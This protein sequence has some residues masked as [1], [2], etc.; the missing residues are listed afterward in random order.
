ME[1]RERR[2]RFWVALQP[3][4]VRL[5][6]VA[7]L[8][9]L[10]AILVGLAR[11]PRRQHLLLLRQPGCARSCCRRRTRRSSRRRR[12]L[13]DAQAAREP[14][15]HREARDR[16]ATSP[17][18]SA[19]SRSTTSSSPT[20]AP[21]PMRR[22]R[23]SSGCS[24]AR[25]IEAKLDKENAV[26]RRAPL[27]AR[28][29]SLALR[30]KEQE[31]VVNRLEQSPYLRAVNGKVVLAFVPYQNLRNIKIGTKLYGCSWG[32]VVCSRV[33]K[34]K[35]D[36]RRRGAGH[37][38]ARRE[39]AARRDGRDRAVDAVGRR[40]TPCCSPAASRSGCS[41]PSS[42]AELIGID[43]VDRDRLVLECAA[44]SAGA[45]SQAVSWR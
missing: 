20:S 40:R 45:Q 14:A 34:V 13:A 38:P 8:V 3:S 4:I 28:L 16:G 7:G 23:P 6:K 32:L 9:A 44:L 26:G 18:S 27:E 33:G 15:R 11:L 10:T 21:P 24:A 36:A 1:A 35:S 5:Y 19:R 37:P 17:R 29:E 2:P 43:E 42:S 30:I 39:R 31:A 22:R 12:Q 41:K 25:S